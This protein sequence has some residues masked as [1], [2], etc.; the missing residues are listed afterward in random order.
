M[1][2]IQRVTQPQDIQQCHAIRVKVFVE[3]QNISLEEEF[4]GLDVQSDHY[5]LTIDKAPI[6]TARVRYD[7][8]KA[9]IERVAILST[10]Q[11]HGL[12]KQLME[13]MIADIKSS[14]KCNTIILGAQTH[15]IP[16]YEKLGF[17]VSSD[18]FMDAGIPHKNM[19][20]VL[21]R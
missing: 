10:H 16:F 7:E 13:I 19:T 2:T 18:V 12:G 4:D 20:L 21:S 14:K 3:E 1:I 15:A 5:L 8:G 17:M 11:G 9:K 6:G